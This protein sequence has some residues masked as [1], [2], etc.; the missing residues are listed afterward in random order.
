MH[1]WCLPFFPILRRPGKGAPHF[2]LQE[3]TPKGSQ[4]LY[5]PDPGHRNRSVYAGKN[6]ITVIYKVSI[7]SH[8]SC[9]ST[10]SPGRKLQPRSSLR[11]QSSSFCLLHWPNV[12]FQVPPGMERFNP[13]KLTLLLETVPSRARTN[14]KCDLNRLRGSRTR[15]K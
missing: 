6:I 12:L 14:W 15:P 3:P 2:S 5:I 11:T 8:T 13:L 9:R 7:R 4:I 10:V 1:S